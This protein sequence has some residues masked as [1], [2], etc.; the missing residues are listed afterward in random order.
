MT[1]DCPDADASQR[2]QREGPQ[3]EPDN[4]IK[5]CIF[6]TGNLSESLCSD[7]EQK[8]LFLLTEFHQIQTVIFYDRVINYFGIKTGYCKH[9]AARSKC[10]AGSGTKHLVAPFETV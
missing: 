5:V 6:S 3:P 8:T 4:V 7:Q 9:W 1:F 10:S 2:E